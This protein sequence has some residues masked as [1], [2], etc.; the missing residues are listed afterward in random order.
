M[1]MNE[2]LLGWSREC[3][4]KGNKSIRERQISYG[5]L[6]MWNLRKQNKGAKEKKEK[7]R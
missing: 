5:L 4:V 2:I 3:N 7:E 1:K 6:H